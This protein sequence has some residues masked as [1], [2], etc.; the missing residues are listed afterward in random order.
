MGFLHAA[1]IDAGA[2]WS[3]IPFDSAS[4][5][6]GD[7]YPTEG[8]SLMALPLGVDGPLWNERVWVNTQNES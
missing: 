8:R 4:R 5:V 3:D 7:F 2:G 6:E 1:G